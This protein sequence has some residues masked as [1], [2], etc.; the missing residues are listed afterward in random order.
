MRFALQAEVSGT[1]IKLPYPVAGSYNVKANGVAKDYTPW[2]SSLGRHGPLTKAK[3]CGENRYV[4]IENFLEFYITPGCMIVIEPRDAIV[5]KVRL[6]WTL[7]AFY[8]DGGVTRFVDRVA[9]S[10]G[11]PAY[12][13]KTVAVYE[14]SVIVDFLIEAEDLTEEEAKT[15]TTG[16]QLNALK[17]KLV[18]GVQDGAFDLG[19]PVIG[20]EGAN[21]ELLA[22]SPI[23]GENARDDAVESSAIVRDGNLWDDLLVDRDGNIS[24][25]EATTTTGE[26]TQGGSTSTETSTNSGDNTSSTG[27]TE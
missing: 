8:A 6:D 26:T 16:I 10:L 22:G 24:I 5:T 15:T 18:L 23:P 14:G 1:K 12:R 21:G 11:I 4:G 19:A 9:A 20:L 17:E 3:G 27:T 7:A 2:D 13:I 25:G